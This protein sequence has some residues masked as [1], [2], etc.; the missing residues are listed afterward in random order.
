MWACTNVL[1]RLLRSVSVTSFLDD[2]RLSITNCS[3][4][5]TCAGC[6]KWKQKY[7]D[8]EKKFK[9]LHECFAINVAE[10]P[11]LHAGKETTAWDMISKYHNK[12]SSV[13]PNPSRYKLALWKKKKKKKSSETMQFRSVGVT[14]RLVI[15]HWNN[16]PAGVSKE[17]INSKKMHW[18]TLSRI[19]NGLNVFI[20]RYT[21]D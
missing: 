11:P 2:W 5:K 9:V 4:I 12:F 15:C 7:Y 20:I 3:K 14:S 13:D 8:L 19:G 18:S 16:L 6:I 1:Q 17:T 10:T 21:N